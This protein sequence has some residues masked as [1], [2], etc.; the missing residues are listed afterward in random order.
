[1]R[2]II[3]IIVVIFCIAG[4]NKLNG[5]NRT[6]DSLFSLLKIVVADT[7]K[8]NI[9]TSLAYEFRSNNSDTSIYFANE[10][11]TL[12]TRANY[13]MGIANA[14]RIISV[15]LM[16]LGKYDEALKKGNN[17]IIIYDQLLHIAEE[18]KNTEKI[19]FIYKQ[20]ANASHTLGNIYI[21]QGNYTKALEEY[22]VSLKIREEIRDSG[23]I[24][25]SFMSIGNIYLRQGNNPKA[26]QYYSSAL[27]I[28]LESG[29]DKL[30]I[31][32]C[33]LNIGNIYLRQNNYV[34]ALNNYNASLK[35]KQEINDKRG[36]GILYNNIGLL[37]SEQRNYSEALINHL[38][39]LKIREEIG[40]T[41][42]IA[43]TYG[44]Y[45]KIYADQN[46]YS[47]A[48]KNYFISTK[49]Y[50]QIGD[51]EGCAMMYAN[52]ANM[53]S[54]QKNNVNAYLF[55]NKSLRL[56]KEIG[57]NVEI[58]HAYGVLAKI[59]SS[60]GNYE[61]ALQHYKF[62]IIYR[63]SLIN[64][65]NTKKIVQTQM[66]YDFD[67]KESLAKAEQEKKDV[68]AFKELQKQKMV[69][70]GFVGG[71][72]VVLLF[73]TIF[74]MQR[75]KISKGKKRSDE[76]LL[77]I[78]PAEVA[79]E[80]KQNGS[81]EAKQF[82]EV[83]VM[84]T[85]F[86]NF[87]RISEELTPS[88]LVGEIHTCF[89]AFDNFISKHNIEKIKTI[90]DSY[91]CA[92]GLPVDNKTNATDVIKAALEILEFMQEH[93]K[94]RLSTNKVPFEIRIGIHTGPVVAGIVGVKK[95]AY[96]IW[97][98]TVNIASR[99]ESSGEAGRINISGSSYELVK[100]KFN[101]TYRGKITAKNKGE[102][103]MYFVEAVL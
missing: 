66:Q 53:Y 11:L 101:C 9:L 83:T 74:F 58:E 94:N 41:K 16:N 28:A 25:I 96:D 18:T 76:L 85:D 97:G 23:S 27:K 44:N 95:F 49:T 63:D 87:T 84:F 8:V 103:D 81:A 98:D 47:E 14:N 77:N 51:Q 10:A 91:M 72:G 48:L 69:R 3:S 1:M 20:I 34:E 56:A 26:F 21:S 17:A 38:A 78:L 13:Q 80:L 2:N 71:F 39:A 43:D 5:Q 64:E 54:M 40:D 89:K 70:N 30:L 33:Y 65:E 52:I 15:P 46:N 88:E 35:I 100:G 22:S 62:Y 31:G 86:K 37:Y 55:A 67:I 42:G 82:D 6:A 57:S 93:L 90:G 50:E 79:E 12:A 92:G 32:N 99:M 4:N 102:I 59:D 36:T 73:A 68:V 75:N 61:Q 19:K 24:G 45:G 7:S 60:Q 29:E